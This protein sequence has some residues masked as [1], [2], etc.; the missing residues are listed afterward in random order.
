MS[1][2]DS[3]FDAESQKIESFSPNIYFKKIYTHVFLISSSR[4]IQPYIKKNKKN[5]CFNFPLPAPY[6]KADIFKILL[7]KRREIIYLVQL[8]TSYG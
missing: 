8:F 2:L 1:F 7:K 3:V 5:F 4:S 6:I